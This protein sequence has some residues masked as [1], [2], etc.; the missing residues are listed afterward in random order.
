MKLKMTKDNFE[1]IIMGWVDDLNR[2]VGAI[3]HSSEI[4]FSE[5]TSFAFD[6][7]ISIKINSDNPPFAIVKFGEELLTYNF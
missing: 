5:L 7:N 6:N 2:D 1:K 4:S 3:Y